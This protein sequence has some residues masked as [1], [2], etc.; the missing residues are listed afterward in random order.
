[1]LV[2]VRF[3]HVTFTVWHWGRGKCRRPHARTHAHTHARSGPAEEPAR[4]APG[5]GPCL[6]LFQSAVLLGLRAQPAAPGVLARRVRLHGG[7]CGGEQQT[8]G[9]G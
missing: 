2:P 1:M 9:S 3:K 8:V 4:A 5:A 6:L 7:G